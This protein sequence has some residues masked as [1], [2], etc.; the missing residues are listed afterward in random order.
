MCI[1]DSASIDLR[2][3]DKL[4]GV[5]TLEPTNLETIFGKVKI[6][7]GHIRMI[8]V[9]LSGGAMSG[10][11]GQGLVL[12]Y[13]FDNDNGDRI[14]DQSGKRNDGVVKG[15]KWTPKGIRGGAYRFD[16][17]DDFIDS[18]NSSLA[19][20]FSEVT[21]S[22]WA[23]TSANVPYAGIAT[24]CSQNSKDLLMMS[25]GPAGKRQATF[26]VG[27]GARYD[28]VSAVPSGVFVPDTWHHLAGTWKSPKIGGD[29]LLRM[30]FDGILN[31]TSTQPLDGVISQTTSLKIGWDDVQLPSPENRRFNGLID[32]VMIFNRALS[33]SEIKQIYDAQK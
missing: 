14:I 29:G 11:L 1:R 21:L 6:G 23:C 17:V 8:N 24:A 7:L 2:N 5:I 31:S 13:S 28:G 15:A 10:A 32:E 4:K 16:G 30:Y 18:G 22:V 26:Y 12:Y 9:L 27:N 33:D 3:G 25:E 19:N 20:G